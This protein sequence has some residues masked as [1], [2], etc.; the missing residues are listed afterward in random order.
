[1]IAGD[2]DSYPFFKIFKNLPFEDFFL[3]VEV[4]G[5]IGHDDCEAEVERIA[6]HFSLLDYSLVSGG[7]EDELVLACDFVVLVD[8]DGITCCPLFIHNVYIYSHD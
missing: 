7:L 5:N 4:T 6:C 3:C 2:V 1:V 8:A